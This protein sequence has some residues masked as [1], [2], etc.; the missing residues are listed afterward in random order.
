MLCAARPGKDACSGDSGGPLIVR[1]A[2]HTEDVVVGI[3]SW[4]TGCANPRYP[5]VYSRI[6]MA[7]DWIMDTVGDTV[8]GCTDS[9]L[10]FS[11]RN[12]RKGCDYIAANMD[13]CDRV[14]V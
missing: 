8:G 3:V 9:P 1:G 2:D 4:G 6:S 5:G 13:L 11:A 7:Y 14:D 10:P 12:G